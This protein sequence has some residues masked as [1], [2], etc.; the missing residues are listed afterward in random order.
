MWGD[1]EAWVLSRVGGKKG[2]GEVGHASAGRPRPGEPAGGPGDGW[3]LLA[4]GLLLWSWHVATVG[5]GFWQLPSSVVP[6]CPHLWFLFVQSLPCSLPADKVGAPPRPGRVCC[7]D[8]LGEERTNESGDCPM[9]LG[10]VH[11][12]PVL[13]FKRDV[14]HLPLPVLSWVTFLR[15]PVHAPSPCF[16]CGPPGQ[17]SGPAS[18][19]SALAARSIS[20]LTSAQQGRCSPHFQGNS[21]REVIE[22]CA[23]TQPLR[24]SQDLEPGLA[25]SIVLGAQGGD[26]PPPVPISSLLTKIHPLGLH[27][28]RPDSVWPV[29][30]LPFPPSQILCAHPPP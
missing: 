20:I 26:P 6:A 17:W 9:G 28:E 3:R 2:A 22:Q 24:P 30:E 29:A 19:F 21:L 4:C 7:L 12:F 8:V 14:G 11:L 10:R 1:S 13:I 15:P 18:P 25:D 16:S 23:I 5:S 27:L